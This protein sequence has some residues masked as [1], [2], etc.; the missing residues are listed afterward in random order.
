MNHKNNTASFAAWRCLLEL[1]FI[2]YGLFAQ[3]GLSA[4]SN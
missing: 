4:V 1:Y 2:S 3:G